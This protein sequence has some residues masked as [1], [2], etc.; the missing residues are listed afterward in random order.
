MPGRFCP[1]WPRGSTF[2]NG[3]VYQHAVTFN[4]F[5]DLAVGEYESAY[6]AF[7][8]VLPTNPDNF[9]ARRTSEPY[10]TG[11]FYCGPAYQRFGQ[12]FFTWFTGNPAWLL[13]AG[14]EEILGVKAD[15]NGLRIAPKVPAAWSSYKVK[16]CYRGTVYN[17]EFRRAQAGQAKG[18]WVNGARVEGNLV[19]LTTDKEASIFF[20]Y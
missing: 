19:P 17:A 20:F 12:N 7:V 8:N 1:V 18:L 14:F 15:Y 5:A 6:E 4:I 10:C 13:K 11:N 3:S 2:E 16:R 9:D